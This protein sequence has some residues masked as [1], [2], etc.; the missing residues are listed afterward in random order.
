MFA[1]A[2]YHFIVNAIA[3]LVAA[4]FLPGFTLTGSIPAF[5]ILTAVFTLIHLIISPIIKFVLSPII[6]LTLGLGTIIINAAILY[7][8]DIYSSNIKIDGFLPLLYATL[9]ITGV[10][11]ILGAGRRFAKRN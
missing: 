5:L 4:Y 9:I 7:F 11:F 2:I 1:S 8:I 3:L 10:N 6:F